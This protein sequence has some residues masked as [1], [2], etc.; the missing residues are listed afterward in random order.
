MYV[1][2]RRHDV[3]NPYTGRYQWC[4]SQTPTLASGDPW[5]ALSRDRSPTKGDPR[6]PTPLHTTPPYAS[7]HDHP[8]N[9][10]L[11]APP[12]P[13]RD[14]GRSTRPRLIPRGFLQNT[15]P[16]RP[17]RTPGV[18]GLEGC[19]RG[20]LSRVIANHKEWIV[21]IDLFRTIA[22]LILLSIL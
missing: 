12:R 18:I 8:I 4:S 17:S 7:G 2:R 19:R 14:R 3:S 20:R 10:P 1:N 11:R 15:Y 13:L 21:G 6:V 22:N 16:C 9:L 5:V